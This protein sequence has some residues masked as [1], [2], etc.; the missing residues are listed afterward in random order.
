MSRDF[1]TTHEF[2]INQT[3]QILQDEGK[4]TGVNQ[5]PFSVGER[6]G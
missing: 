4:I 5:Y 3:I 1:A 2:G 6:V